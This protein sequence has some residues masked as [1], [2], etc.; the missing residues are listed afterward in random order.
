MRFNLDRSD[1]GRGLSAAAG[2]GATV[3]RFSQKVLDSPSALSG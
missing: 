1:A 3:A 2:A